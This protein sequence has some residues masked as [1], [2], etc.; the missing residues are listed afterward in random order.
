MRKIIRYSHGF[1]MQAVKDVERGQGCASAV[2]AAGVKLGRD[3]LFEELSQAGLL[4][5]KKPPAWP[6]P[7]QW[8]A[9]LPVFKNLIKDWKV[10]RPN[11]VW[12]ADITYIRT[13]EAFFYLG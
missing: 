2:K 4:V 3:R 11:Q 8:D 1:K 7:T 13:R 5:A 9:H 10:T 6:R 12:V